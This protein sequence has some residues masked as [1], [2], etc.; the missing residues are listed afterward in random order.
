M[1]WVVAVSV[2]SLVEVV[3]MS[4]ESELECPYYDIFT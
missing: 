2:A 3:D 1:K 4:D